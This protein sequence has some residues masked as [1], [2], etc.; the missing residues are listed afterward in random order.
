MGGAETR[1]FH[2][3]MA[4][5]ADPLPVRVTVEVQVD[6]GVDAAH[7]AA[8]IK[9]ADAVA[10]IRHHA[11]VADR[12]GGLAGHD[13]G[14]DPQPGR[15]LALEGKTGHAPHLDGGIEP[16]RPLSGLP[17]TA[18]ES[19]RCQPF[20]A[21]GHTTAHDGVFGQ[22]DRLEPTAQRG[23]ARDFLAVCQHARLDELDAL[24]RT[25]GLGD[26]FQWHPRCRAAQIVRQPQDAPLGIRF[27]P[28]D[29][30][31]HQPGDRAAMEQAAVPW[32]VGALGGDVERPIAVIKR[33]FHGVIP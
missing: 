20:G 4:F 32:G 19:F 1:G 15:A 18:Q 8:E 13:I 26:H 29:D 2:V 33:I 5:E 16:G 24:A 25:Q 10:E 21:V 14:L 9:L 11:H 31:G 17:A 23:A 7:L 6:V 22:I 12:C 28:I 27:M 3:G 30:M